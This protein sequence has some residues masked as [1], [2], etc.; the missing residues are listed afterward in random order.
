MADRIISVL[1]KSQ[2]AYMR[3]LGFYDGKIDGIWGQKSRAAMTLWVNSGNFAPGNKKRGDGPII[4][5][6]RLPKG[7]MWEVLDGQRCIVKQ[8]TLPKSFVMHELVN[9]LTQ[10]AKSAK[11]A[12]NTQTTNAASVA[13]NSAEIEKPK[14][15]GT[16]TD[17]SVINSQS[18]ADTNS[19][20]PNQNMK[21]QNGGNHR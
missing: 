12:Q 16:K 14:T 4:P 3:E 2:Q 6:E 20:K 15:E 13:Q 8:T 9:L 5:F 11:V 1:N 10:E 18:S 19:A 7:Y 17:N 21:H